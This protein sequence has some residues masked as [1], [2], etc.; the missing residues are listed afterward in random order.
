MQKEQQ[1]AAVETSAG[2]GGCASIKQVLSIGTSVC[3]IVSLRIRIQFSM[4]GSRPSLQ[5]SSET[6]R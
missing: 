2:G 5:N 6:P 4:L 3:G 1:M